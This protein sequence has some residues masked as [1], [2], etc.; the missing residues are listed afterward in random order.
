MILGP[1]GTSVEMTFLRENEGQDDE[2]Y[3]VKLIRGGMATAA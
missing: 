2:E 1:I 3:T